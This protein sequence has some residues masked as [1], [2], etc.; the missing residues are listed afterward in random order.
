MKLIKVENVKVDHVMWVNEFDM[1]KDAIVYINYDSNELDTDKYEGVKTCYLS[2]F[3]DSG[4]FDDVVFKVHSDYDDV[5]HYEL[6]NLEKA[7]AMTLIKEYLY[8]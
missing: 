7:N 8:R 5:E 4:K 6:P 3:S 2:V 1:E